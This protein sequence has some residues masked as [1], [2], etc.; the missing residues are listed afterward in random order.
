VD[1]PRT[2]PLG[3]QCMR[4]LV[5]G[6]FGVIRILGLGV[7]PTRPSSDDSNIV[8]VSRY[9][10]QSRLSHG[11]VG[12]SDDEVGEVTFRT[13]PTIAALQLAPGES[14]Q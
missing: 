1:E 8:G 14:S 9:R 10:R 5:T 12:S 4:S 7:N 2:V 3:H 11:E 13:T 6:V